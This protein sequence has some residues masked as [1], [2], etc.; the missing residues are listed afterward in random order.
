MKTPAVRPGFL[1]TA[2]NFK[3]QMKNLPANFFNGC[4][5]RGDSSGIN[6]DQVLPAFSQS[7]I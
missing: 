1:A 5:C 4:I 3:N 7:A 2:G 6:V